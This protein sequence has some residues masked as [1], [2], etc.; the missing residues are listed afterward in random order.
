MMWVAMHLLIYPIRNEKTNNME[1][2]EEGKEEGKV[3]FS[4]RSSGGGGEISL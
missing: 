4:S 3:C 2:D 1:M